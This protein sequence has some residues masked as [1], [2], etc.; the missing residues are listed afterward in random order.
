MSDFIRL[1]DKQPIK[2]GHKRAVYQHP[3]D[4][5]LLIKIIRPDMFEKRWGDGAP[6]YKFKR[7]SG[8]YINFRREV[9][10]YICLR[11][12]DRDPSPSIQ[13]ISG[14]VETDLG[15]GLVVEKLVDERGNL[16]PTLKTVLMQSGLTSDLKVEIQRLIAELL[17]TG[18]ILSKLNIRNVLL[19]YDME[20]GRRLVIID[21]MGSKSLIPIFAISKLANAYNTRRL[22]RQMEAHI[23][24]RLKTNFGQATTAPDMAIFS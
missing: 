19:A 18:V 5:R 16:A 3:L 1:S 20:H 17:R 12:Q 15:L 24:E 8:R 14:L 11:A 9:G 4:P 10:E 7:R 22:A 6:W 2:M 23:Q 13:K 21:G